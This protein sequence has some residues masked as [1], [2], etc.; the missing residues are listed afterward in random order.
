VTEPVTLAPESVRAVAH[1]VVELLA[2]TQPPAGRLVDA[3][4]L[5]DLLGVER[6]W[7]YE[8]A[9]RLGAF[10]I[11]DGPR[12]RLRF[13]PETALAAWKARDP[14]PAPEPAPRPPRRRTR[15]RGPEL[16][17]IGGRAA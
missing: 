14:E 9:E 16:L 12:G 15:P 5:A 1:A 2:D 10:R 8:H 11:G 13:D 4:Q 17:P 6:S 7:V 3:A